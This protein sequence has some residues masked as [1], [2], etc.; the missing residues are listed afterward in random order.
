[1]KW[2]LVCELAEGGQSHMGGSDT[3][4]SALFY[5]THPGTTETTSF[6]NIAGE[7]MMKLLQ[8]TQMFL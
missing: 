2:S 3:G 6:A 8:S 1:M 5:M 4:S 7:L